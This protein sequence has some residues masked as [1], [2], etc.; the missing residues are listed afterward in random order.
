MERNMWTFDFARLLVEWCE[1][2]DDSIEASLMVAKDGTALWELTEYKTVRENG[3]SYIDKIEEIVV[4]DKNNYV[5]LVAKD[6]KE[7]L[8]TWLKQFNGSLEEQSMCLQLLKTPY[9]TTF[10]RASCFCEDD[11]LIFDVGD[12]KVGSLFVRYKV[13]Q[14]KTEVFHAFCDRGSKKTLEGFKKEYVYSAI[15]DFIELIKKHLKEEC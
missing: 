9:E 15:N 5:L 7:A 13:R 2:T 11:F 6:K 14:N 12:S 1:S 8:Y 3:S 4:V 10:I